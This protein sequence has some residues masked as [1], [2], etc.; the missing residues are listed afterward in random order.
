MDIKPFSPDET[1]DIK[2]IVIDLDGTLLNS[3]H[4]LSDR[5][6]TVI[7]KAIDAGILVV[8]ATG[9]TRASADSVIA[10]LNLTSPG[11]YSQGLVITEGDGS[12]RHQQTMDPAVIRRIVTFAEDR[13]FTVLA[14]SGNRILVKEETDYGEFLEKH[15]EPP[16]TVV[17]PIYNILATTPINKLILAGDK[18][19]VK[20]M[21]WQLSHQLEGEI[22][23]TTANIPTMLEVLPP[24]ASK[25]KALK[26][27]LKDM[28][29]NPDQTMVIGDGENDTGMLQLAG[30]AVAVGNADDRL[31]EAADFVVSSNDDDGVAE[32]IE[33]FALRPQ[34][35]SEASTDETETPDDTGADSS[36]SDDETAEQGDD[37]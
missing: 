4:V 9:K 13:G 34:P 23:I 32:A 25:G 21:R 24:G 22:S 31:K 17:G 36:D 6:Q 29:I 3:E 15:H 28:N 10:A 35:E 7:R 2:L 12:I 20:S 16:A 37:A 14:Y 27:L 30:L 5:N 8:L 19:R 33:R 18:R 1:R 11:I 26:I